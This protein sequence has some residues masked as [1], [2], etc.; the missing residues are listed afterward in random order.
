MLESWTLNDMSSQVTKRADQSAGR[1]MGSHSSWAEVPFGISH[2]P[3]LHCVLT[4]QYQIGDVT[5]GK[6]ALVAM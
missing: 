3:G 5:R 4:I 2:A 1:A 6:N